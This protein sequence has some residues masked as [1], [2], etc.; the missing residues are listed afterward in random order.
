MEGV[1]KLT[2]ITVKEYCDLGSTVLLST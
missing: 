1:N 2:V